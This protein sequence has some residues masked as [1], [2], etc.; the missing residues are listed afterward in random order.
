MTS[1]ISWKFPHPSDK[2]LVLSSHLLC[3]KKSV[4]LRFWP[5]LLSS[6]QCMLALVWQL[7][8]LILSVTS[9]HAEQPKSSA[10]H[11]WAFVWVTPTC[12]VSALYIPALFIWS[13]FC[14][15]SSLCFL[16]RQFTKKWSVA[17]HFFPNT[18]ANANTKYH[19]IKNTVKTA[20]L[21][22]NITI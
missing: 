6:C 13:F 9:C 10:A 8:M 5:P 1:L 18:K 4:F 22:K 16:K 17:L 14:H 2:V 20:I 7:C 3:Q 21:W 11:C 12:A 19:L 15:V